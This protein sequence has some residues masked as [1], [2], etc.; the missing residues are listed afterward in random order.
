MVMVKRLPSILP[1]TFENVVLRDDE[2]SIKNECLKHNKKG[3]SIIYTY[4]SNVYPFYQ[5]SFILDKILS[6]IFPYPIWKF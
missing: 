4:C 2:V 5:V 6:S 1:M 3:T